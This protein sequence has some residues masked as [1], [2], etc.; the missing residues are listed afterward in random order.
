MNRHLQDLISSISLEDE[1]YFNRREKEIQLAIAKEKARKRLVH[2]R[3]EKS[4]V[5]RRFWNE[6]FETFIPRTEEE[7]K[8]LL[9]VTNYSKIE[10]N[11]RVLAFCGKMGNGKTHLAAS[12]IREVGGYMISSQDIIYK[13]DS[14]MNFTNKITKD[15]LVAFYGKVKMLVIDEIGRSNTPDKERDILSFILCKRYDYKLPS[16][17]ISNMNK[18]ELLVF[19][20]KA[21][22]DRLK[23]TC[24][25]LEF[26]NE[27]YRILKRKEILE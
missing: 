24:T 25:I 4:G 2:Y 10:D 19:L 12:V 1:E 22:L 13:F 15:D 20:G 8:I 26:T 23:E 6:S 14:S 3:S 7:K 17:L 18:N 9:T 11:E 16:I 21:V 27:S 5:P